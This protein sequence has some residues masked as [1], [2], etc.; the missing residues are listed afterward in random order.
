M[1]LS[2]RPFRVVVPAL[3]F[4][5]AAIIHTSIAGIV[6]APELDAVERRLDELG[7]LKADLDLW[8]S[9]DSTER[10]GVAWS[11]G[12]VKVLATTEVDVQEKDGRRWFDFSAP[13][14]VL[15][16]E[17]ALPLGVYTLSTWMLMP[18]PH[19]HALI[20]Q[21]GAGSGSPLFVSDTGLYGWNELRHA[22]VTF[23]LLPKGFAGWHHFAVTCDGRTTTAFLDGLRVG[24]VPEVLAMNLRSIGNHWQRAH[25]HW[26]MCAA[27]DDQLIFR[28]PLTEPEVRKVMKFGRPPSVPFR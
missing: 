1:K 22:Q 4:C 19:H 14:A 8:L 9:M 7:P 13:G 10:G 12:R 11:R 16:F 23:A 5:G 6:A 21:G 24:S 2:P 27:L 26:M 28:R 3:L 18:P 15:K 20:W 25:Q 17:P